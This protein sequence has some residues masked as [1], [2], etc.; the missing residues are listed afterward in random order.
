MSIE[1]PAEG[2]S[3]PRSQPPADEP[4]HPALQEGEQ[5]AVVGR[6]GAVRCALLAAI[7]PA[8]AT[9]IDL[10]RMA[11]VAAAVLATEGQAGNAEI[12]LL[13][14]D[15]AEIRRLNARFRAVDRETDVLAFPQI[16]PGEA[17]R[18]PDGVLRFGDVVVSYER[19]VEQAAAEGHPVARELDLLL[20]HGVLH[21]LGHTD[22]TPQRRRRMLARGEAVVGGLDMPPGAEA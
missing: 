11:R 13:V 7:L 16:L 6:H 17:A 10:A 12:S 5:H 3:E 4:P 19:A 18:D 14:T 15:N 22:D 20:A 21:L 2:R 8:F 1:P 9:A